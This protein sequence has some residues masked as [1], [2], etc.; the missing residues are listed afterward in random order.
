[1]PSRQRTYFLLRGLAACGVPVS[2]LMAPGLDAGAVAVTAGALELAS[3]V[4]VNAGADGERAGARA[5]ERAWARVRPPQ[6]EWPPYPSERVV[7]GELRYNMIGDTCVGIIHKK[8]KAGGISAVG[9]TGNQVWPAAMT[10][11]LIST[12]VVAMPSCCAVKRVRAPA[13]VTA[14]GTPA[15]SSVRSAP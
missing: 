7:E 14:S 13:P 3:C 6:G 10:S 8:P 5:Q 15:H 1:M 4:G 9:G 12:A 2:A 11:G